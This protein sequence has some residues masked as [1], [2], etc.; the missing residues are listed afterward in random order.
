MYLVSGSL[1]RQAAVGLLVAEATLY[2]MLAGR[3]LLRADQVGRIG[4][5]RGV[6]A[7]S[8]VTPIRLLE[9]G[10]TS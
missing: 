2:Y 3:W 7:I 8:S 1:S 5:D 10:A 6:S 9:L 4:G